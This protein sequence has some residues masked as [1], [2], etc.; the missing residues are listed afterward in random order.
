M[1]EQGWM[2]GRPL[3]LSELY[4][5]P[6]REWTLLDVWKAMQRRKAWLYWSVGAMLALA[7]AYCL[8]A[9]PRFEAT[10]EIEVQRESPAAFGLESS[11]NGENAQADADSLDYSMTL[12]TEAKILESPTL[13]L[14][15]MRDVGLETTHDYFP[16]HTSGWHPPAWL[17]FWRKPL[18]PMNI[19]L[20]DA[21][22]RRYTALKTFTS[23]LKVKAQAG[24]RLIDVSY[25]NP[26][27]YLAT[28]VVNRLLLALTEYT[29]QARFEAT[30][31]ASDWLAGQ[32]KGLRAQ[33]QTLEARADRL[34]RDTGI[35]GDD[36]G[37][38]IV[39]D[40]LT[41]LNQRLAAAETNRILM[42]AVEQA[43]SGGD[44]ELLPA[45]T[46]SGGNGAPGYGPQ[47]TVVQALRTREAEL[48]AEIA[49]NDARYGP[50][51]PRMAEL[52]AELGGVQKSIRDEAARMDQRAKTDLQIAV[53]SENAARDAFDKQRS[54]ADAVSSRAVTYQLARQEA[55]SSRTVYD[56][57]LAKLKQAGVLEGLRSTNL[58]VV[59]PAQ[60][61]PTH[62]PS[63]PRTV[64]IYAGAL[65]GGLMLGCAGGWTAERFDP[66]VRSLNQL[67]QEAGAP[68]LGVLPDF[69]SLRGTFRRG[70]RVRPGDAGE[71]QP[72]PLFLT[73]TD[74]PDRI[75][76]GLFL[77]ALRAMRTSLLRLRGGRRSQVVLISSAVA[78]EGKSTIAANLAGMMAQL[79]K[80][81]LLVDADLRRP[82]I[83]R[84]LG[85]VSGPGL[86]SA[87]DEGSRP[88]IRRYPGLPQL[89]VLCGD[90][91]AS[92]P[93]ELLASERMH[94]LLKDWRLDYDVVLLDSPPVLSA[95]DAA[96]LAQMSDVTILVARHGSTA[97]QAVRRSLA[98]L[99]EH[100]PEGGTL[101]VVLNGIMHAS[102]DFRDYYG[103][104]GGRSA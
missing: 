52:Q 20:E 76:L 96:L 7:T 63:S 82:D 70:G 90:A 61:P 55:D 46:G 13:A 83:H 88:V 66:S 38:N 1:R 56:S 37:H 17:F 3:E 5:H 33:T 58:T 59:A 51:H 43:A 89:S 86:E 23:H 84:E 29:Y 49:E 36:A 94:D 64:L 79:G 78:G 19:R 6:R 74:V 15:V 12:E 99:Q 31:Q 41:A 8:L 48:E 14:K 40:R 10:G 2:A 54:L 81:V 72:S 45:L 104:I 100:I 68:L 16:Q 27:P 24:T 87:L 50:S 4:M 98:V 93:A 62:R 44:P 97:H 71:S 9:T 32:L 67:E 21:P 28:E 34:Q 103:L 92:T 69:G 60:V 102:H 65:M 30:A 47:L 73:Q 25:S 57:L 85:V 75:R 26:D 39:L 77:E 101:R 18:E 95:T 53:A 35:Y 91:A 22:N 11:V 80:R 42:Q